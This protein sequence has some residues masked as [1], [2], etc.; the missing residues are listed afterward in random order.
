MRIFV[1][2]QG[3]DYFFETMRL[4]NTLVPILIQKDSS[5][6]IPMYLYCRISGME[7]WY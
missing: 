7:R 3:A 1:Q 5:V 4:A 2:N 6:R